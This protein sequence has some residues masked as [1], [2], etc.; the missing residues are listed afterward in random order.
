MSEIR[1]ILEEEDSLLQ[2]ADVVVI[3][4]PVDELSDEEMIEDDAILINE[5]D[6]VKQ[7]N[8]VVGTLELHY[9]ADSP[10]ENKNEQ[11]DVPPSPPTSPDLLGIAD[12]PEVS[13][14]K[15]CQKRKPL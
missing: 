10:K 9:L 8:D 7:L 12:A 2:E 6:V 11:T 1:E 14:E 4:P 13:V 5:N 15:T 3:P